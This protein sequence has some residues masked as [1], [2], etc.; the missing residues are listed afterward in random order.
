MS[1]FS[2]ANFAKKLVELNNT[3]QSI[4]TL[5][6]WLIH[7]RKHSKSIVQVWQRELQK[8][9]PAKRLIFI[10]LANDVIQ[11][12]KKKG[13]ELSRDFATVLS[14][15]IKCTGKNS[16][17]KMKERVGRV[18]GI[19]LER[20]V[21][22]KEFV[23]GLKR[24]LESPIPEPVPPK[25]KKQDQFMTLRQEVDAMDGVF[26]PPHAEE[27]VKRLCDLETSASSDAA[28]REKIAALPPEVSDIS[29]LEK[30]SDK[31]SGV[32]LVKQVD[33]ACQLLTDYNQRLTDELEERKK[34]A[35]MLREFIKQQ[36][37]ELQKSESRLHE[38]QSKLSKVSAVRN[39]L[40]SHLQ[41][42][43]DLTLLPD[44]TGGLAPLPS[45][46]DLFSL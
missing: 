4:Q 16:D 39:E 25:K 30:I 11:N 12:S 36:K 37:G 6:L 17:D 26:D 5:S 35:K 1:S 40:K 8:A 13:P 45:A 14:D 18:L 24:H 21:Y 46:G 41:N 7:H 10:Y 44:V 22:D 29:H 15:A 27:L 2:D 34:V 38:Y 28:V 32:K 9:K 3:Q 19:W 23:R 31:E 43:P 33:N 20:G 42:L